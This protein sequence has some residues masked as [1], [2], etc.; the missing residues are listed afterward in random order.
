MR[1]DS[2]NEKTDPLATADKGQGREGQ[3]L[4]SSTSNSNVEVISDG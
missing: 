2:K 3:I 1:I 4:K